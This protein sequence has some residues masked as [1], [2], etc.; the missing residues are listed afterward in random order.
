MWHSEVKASKP[1]HAL[2]NK[3]LMHIEKWFM[4]KLALKEALKPNDTEGR[5]C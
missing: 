2:A 5:K 1:R 3:I 4:P